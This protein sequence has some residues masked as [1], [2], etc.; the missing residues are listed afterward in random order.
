MLH[1][2]LHASVLGSAV[3]ISAAMLLWGG[4][5]LGFFAYA[6]MRGK[7]KSI[8]LLVGILAAA[9]G[10]GAFMNIVRGSNGL[11]S[12]T[13]EAVLLGGFFII[14]A[15]LTV[16]LGRVI[17]DDFSSRTVSKILEAGILAVV[18]TGM[19]LAAGYRVAETSIFPFSF[20]GSF[21]TAPEALLGW[22]VASLAALY[23]VTR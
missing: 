7:G 10:S 15:A 14:I 20:A 22:F 23:F 13:K 11:S 5:A 1:Q 19:F 4:L 18:S 12:G 21:V 16:V 3:S 17:H 2:T 6:L 8:S 9:G